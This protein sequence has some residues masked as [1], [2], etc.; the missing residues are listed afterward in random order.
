MNKSTK[1][2]IVGV[3]N[4]LSSSLAK[5]LYKEGMSISLAARN[6]EKLVNLKKELNANVFKCDASLPDDVHNLF[7]ELDK[8]NEQPNFVIYNPSARVT[9]PI[10]ELDILKT[11]N[12]VDVT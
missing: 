7:I 4:G 11:R 9:G 1:V 2:L 8:M 6:V 3:G 10:E 12:A 5:L